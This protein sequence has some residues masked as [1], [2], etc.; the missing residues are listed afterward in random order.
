MMTATTALI[1]DEAL[2]ELT[3]QAEALEAKRAKLAAD[4]AAAR[5]EADAQLAA[6]ADGQGDSRVLADAQARASALAA[7]LNVVE[8]QLASKRAEMAPCH[9]REERRALEAELKRE[10]AECTR[11]FRLMCEARERAI[12]HIGQAVAGVDAEFRA[13]RAAAEAAQARFM[14]A[15]IRYSPGTHYKHR[16]DTAAEVEAWGVDLSVVRLRIGD[17]HILERSTTAPPE[18]QLP[19][20]GQIGQVFDNIAGVPAKWVR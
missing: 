10:A 20:R 14:E 18:P 5:Q 12:Q 16:W 2:A 8:Q 17:C 19:W 13:H 4:L 1:A 9:A 7:A 3:A 6:L 15:L 11:E